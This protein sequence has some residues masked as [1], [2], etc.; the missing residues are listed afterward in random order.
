MRDSARRKIYKNRND[1]E[2]YMGWV[3]ILYDLYW[4]EKKGKKVNTLYFPDLGK[5]IISKASNNNNNKK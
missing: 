2:K 3:C 5:F 4:Q 1:L